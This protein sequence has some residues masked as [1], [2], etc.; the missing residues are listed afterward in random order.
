MTFSYSR[1]SG[2]ILGFSLTVFAAGS[3]GASAQEAPAGPANVGACPN[4]NDAAFADPMSKPHWNGWGVEPTQHRFQPADM[5]RLSAS[6]VTR[7]KLKWAFGF[8]GASRAVAQPTVF[9]GRVF[10]GSQNGKLYSLDAKSG[11]EYWEFDAGKGVRSAVVIGP[12]GDS[13]AAYFGDLGANV[14]AVDALTGKSLWSAKIDDHPAAIITGSPTL[15]GTT[16]LVGVSSFEEVTG[17]KPSYSCCTFRGSLVALD[18]SNGKISWKTFTIAEE[19]KPTEPNLNGVQQLG[20]LRQRYGLRRHLMQQ[21]NGSTPRLATITPIHPAELR[22][23][24]SPSTPAPEI[25]L[26]HDRSP[27]ATRIP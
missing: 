15:V 22:T 13:W 20:P 19:A 24:S 2:A 7:L 8:P 12:R 11:C 10:V 14:H 26:G 23:Q 6:D 17:A 4:T 27:R 5:A 16:L 1:L 9:S 18:A 3:F 25:E 21:P